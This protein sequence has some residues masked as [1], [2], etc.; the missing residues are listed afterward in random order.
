M[1]FSLVNTNEKKKRGFFFFFFHNL[2]SK[3]EPIIFNSVKIEEVDDYKNQCSV[4]SA[5]NILF[6][7]GG[8]T[9][10]SISVWILL[11]IMPHISMSHPWVTLTH[12]T[13]FS[14]RG[15]WVVVERE[16]EKGWKKLSEEFLF[17]FGYIIKSMAFLFLS[18]LTIQ[19]P[20]VLDPLSL[21]PL[22]P[23]YHP[24][25]FSSVVTWFYPR[26]C[27]WYFHLLTS[28]R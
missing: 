20:Y 1:C 24:P 5:D 10:E 22:L 28:E 14:C 26:I 12:Q 23:D 15:G 9:F 6:F 8:V 16:R 2:I 17:I 7:F 13:T 4:C 19:V 11:Q 21:L 18:K 25:F 3:I 27:Y